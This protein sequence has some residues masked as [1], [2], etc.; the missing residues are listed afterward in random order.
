M[1]TI[2]NVLTAAM[3]AVS[4]GAMV[5][6]PTVAIAAES[7]E[8]VNKAIAEVKKAL[9]EAIQIAAEGT[10]QKGL[11][12]K[13]AEAKQYYKEITGD[14]YGAKLQRLSGSLSKARG[15]ARRGDLAGAEEEL[16]RAL[17]IINQ[18][19]PS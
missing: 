16:K 11:I 17:E 9:T 7:A 18:F 14:Q 5:G 6:G 15:M 8:G 4:A 1:K 3:I 13:I 12:D 19:Q 2:K 10:N